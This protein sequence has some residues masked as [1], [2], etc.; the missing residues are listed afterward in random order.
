MSRGEDALT[1]ADNRI[2]RLHLGDLY[3]LAT[4]DWKNA[5][6]TARTTPRVLT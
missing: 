1:F 4:R 5:A 2:T 3:R 6:D